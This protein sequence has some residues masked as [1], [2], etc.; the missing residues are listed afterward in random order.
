MALNLYGKTLQSHLLLGTSQYPTLH[1][2]ECSIIS[3]GTE[4]VTVS[5][6][7][8][9][10]HNKEP[11][12]FWQTLNAL[13]ITILPNTAGCHSALEAVAMADMARE[14]F[15][16]DWIKLEVI[17]NDHTLLPNSL[18]LVKAAEIL[19]ENGFDVFPYCADDLSV[20]QQLIALGIDVL[21]P[22][23]S[24]IGSGQ[25][26]RNP[27]GLMMLRNEFPTVQL[28]IDAGIG[29]PSDAAMA[30]QMGFDAILLNSAVS[31]AQQPE[32]MARAF[33][34]AIEAGRLG[35]EAGRMPYRQEANQS[36]P[37][38]DTP[39]WHQGQVS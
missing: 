30:M 29:Q 36:T 5:L 3:S 18:E 34:L 13:P 17:L 35:Y 27:Q 16:T 14:M 39:F 31:Q 23:A 25:G 8:E 12:E 15:K 32:I 7:R 38:I 22:L 10:Q 4:V 26:L 37:L 1:D 21:M 33:Q 19:V 28:I 2:L 9:S 11:S 20:C 6:K 24:P